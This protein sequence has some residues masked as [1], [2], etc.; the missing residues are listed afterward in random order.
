MGRYDL[1]S[2]EPREYLFLCIRT[3]VPGDSSMQLGPQAKEHIRSRV[4]PVLQQLDPQLEFIEILVD[5]ARRQLGFVLQKDDRPIVLGMDWL[6]FVAI[7]EP[8]LKQNLATQLETRG[9]LRP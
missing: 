6:I 7:T 8:E 5:S 4:E 3:G 9:L 2:V 1:A